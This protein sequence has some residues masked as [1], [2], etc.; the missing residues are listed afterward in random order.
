MNIHRP[1][2]STHSQAERAAAWRAAAE[3]ILRRVCPG[4]S[5]FS[6]SDGTISDSSATTRGFQCTEKSLI[7]YRQVQISRAQCVLS[8]DPE[9]TG[10]P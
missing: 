5:I 8:R 7:E 1:S 9:M 2:N 10:I 3:G 6:R 4:E